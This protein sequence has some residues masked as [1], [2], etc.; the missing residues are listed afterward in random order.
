MCVCY[1]YSSLIS[2]FLLWCLDYC[3]S[4]V[5]TFL[6]KHHVC[7]EQVKRTWWWWWWIW[8]AVNIYVMKCAFAFGSEKKAGGGGGGGGGSSW[9]LPDLDLSPFRS[10]LLLPQ[11]FLLQPAAVASNVLA[12]KTACVKVVAGTICRWSESTAKIF[13][14]TNHLLCG[15]RRTWIF[16]P[17][18][19]HRMCEST[20][21]CRKFALLRCVV[22][23]T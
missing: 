12:T 15:L 18:P 1:L 17:T 3:I 14:A 19:A 10:L 22:L 21:P 4:H 16:Y 20:L 8:S 23:V 2:S 11:K 5:Y 13:N 7:L 9:L 6:A